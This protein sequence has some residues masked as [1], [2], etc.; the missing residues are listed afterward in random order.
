MRFFLT[1]PQRARRLTRAHGAMWGVAVLVLLI[2]VLTKHS[3]RRFLSYERWDI[4]PGISFRLFENT[5]GPFGIAPVELA[6]V[7]GAGVLLLW[8]WLSFRMFDERRGWIPPIAVGLLLGGGLSNGLE[9]V[10]AGR[11]T[12]IVWLGER[13]ALNVA[14][15]A[16]LSALV[17]LCIVTARGF[18]RPKRTGDWKSG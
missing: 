2:D 8:I 4:A 1:A 18:M 7:I 15:A 16:I 13:T 3:V 12:D 11:T 5:R 14:D 9:R 17:L 6:A 10:L